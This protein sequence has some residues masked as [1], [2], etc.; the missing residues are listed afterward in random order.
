[1]SEAYRAGGETAD[2]GVRAFVQQVYGWM[3][4]ALAVTGFVALAVS[5]SATMQQLIFG[6][7]F[8]FFGLIVGELLLVVWLAARI[9][10]MSAQ[11]ATTVFVG[12]SVLNGLTMSAIFLVYAQATIAT[13]F[14]VTSGLFA[15]MTLYGF[16][17]KTDLTRMGN[18]LAMALVGF[19]IASLVNLFLRS[20]GL[21]WLITYAGVLIFTGLV[22]YD[23]QRIKEMALAGVGDG[24][25]GRKY[26]IM[27]ALRLYLD[28]VNL[29]LLLLRIFGRRR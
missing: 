8:V 15:V 13:A 29:F 2:A 18:I 27:G 4:A 23:S 3:A 26:A 12:Y 9:G 14:F 21:Y 7:R 11:T 5:R 17:T 1:M 22:G 16:F 28:F 10:R 20:E 19:V 6:S 25:E 24:E